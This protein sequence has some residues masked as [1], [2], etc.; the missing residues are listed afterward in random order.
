MAQGL[1]RAA[2]RP[3]AARR[4]VL[5]RFDGLAAPIEALRRQ[6]EALLAD[7]ESALRTEVV[8]LVAKVAQQVIRSE[9]TAQPAQLLSLVDEALPRCR[10]GPATAIEVFLNRA[11]LE[12]IAQ[13]G[14]A[15]TE[16][17]NLIPDSTLQPG[18]CRIRAGSNEVDAGC[19]RRLEACMEQV[20]TQLL[21]GSP[22]G[23]AAA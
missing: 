17:W 12:R 3:G 4:Q 19:R 23:G 11:D 22:A 15:R 9:L 14:D 7:Y 10:A 6:L 20:G 8:D 2:R 13:L 16:H 5:A 1:P 18:E 21:P